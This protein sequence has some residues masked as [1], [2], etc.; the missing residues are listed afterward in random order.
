M[1]APIAIVALGAALA[2][3]VQGLSGFAFGLVATSVW[4]WVLQ[5][6][7][8]AAMAVFGA[9]TG[10]VIAALTVRRG[11]HWRLL[12][13]FLAGG[14]AGVPLGVLLLPR[15]DVPAFRTLLGLLLVVWCPLMLMAPRLPRVRRGG[16]FADAIA[17]ALGG[18][19]G[20]IGG[21]TGVIPTLWC[22]LR[23]FD[24]D[25]QRAVV[26]NF[27][28]A[29]LAVAMGGYLAGGVVTREMIP[30]FAVV[31]PAMLIPTLIGTRVYIG[32]SEARFRQIVLALLTVSGVAM[33]ASTW[34]EWARRLS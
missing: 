24:K 22:T 7:L 3:F 13:P 9:L 11:F 4:I 33:L 23:G 34:P 26:Q 29:A 15:L 28:L 31:A 19:M 21:Y 30:M 6:Q 32:I 25:A 18:V 17:G 2:G 8:A 1:D 27:N 5:P 12:L 16:R 10:Q 14:A 20:G